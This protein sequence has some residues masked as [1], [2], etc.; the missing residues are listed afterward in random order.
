M[1][2]IHYIRLVVFIFLFGRGGLCE[3]IVGDAVR[4][5]ERILIKVNQK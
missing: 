5:S 1:K 2:V 3:L 4:S